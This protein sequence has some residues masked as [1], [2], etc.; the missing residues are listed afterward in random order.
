MS[1]QLLALAAV[2]GVIAFMSSV[3][4]E[5]ERLTAEQEAVVREFKI[6][7]EGKV[8]HGEW[9]RAVSAEE[10]AIDAERDG[11]RG[12]L[13]HPVLARL[14][15][16]LEKYQAGK[17]APVDMREHIAQVKENHPLLYHRLVTRVNAYRLEHR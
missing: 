9:L 6:E 17:M 8:D 16:D 7:R 11:K 12:E 5:E 3:R 4:A 15:K 2:C 14:K 10:V 1:K 13:W